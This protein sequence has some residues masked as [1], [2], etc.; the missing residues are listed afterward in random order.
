MAKLKNSQILQATENLEKTNN[1]FDRTLSN[2]I[3]ESNPTMKG[4]LYRLNSYRMNN[5]YSIKLLENLYN[6][7]EKIK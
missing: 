6:F 3:N 7:T 5:Y 4:F 1:V 2:Y